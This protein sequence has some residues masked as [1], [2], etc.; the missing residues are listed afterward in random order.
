MGIISLLCISQTAIRAKHMNMGAY[1]LFSL[2]LIP[3]FFIGFPGDVPILRD[4]V[5]LRGYI[6]V[7]VP[8]YLGTRTS[9][10]HAFFGLGT[11]LHATDFFPILRAPTYN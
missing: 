9:Q 2:P 1:F 3:A 7:L 5:F 10:F 6:P 4:V 11:C 8:T